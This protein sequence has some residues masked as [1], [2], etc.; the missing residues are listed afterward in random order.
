MLREDGKVFGSAETIE[1]IYYSCLDTLIKMSFRGM[2]KKRN[3]ENFGAEINFIGRIKR[4]LLNKC[5][6][7]PFQVRTEV[8]N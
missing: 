8:A 6:R 3:G 4:K 2:R 5:A 1:I 7:A